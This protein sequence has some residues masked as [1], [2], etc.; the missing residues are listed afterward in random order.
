VL[1]TNH[2]FHNNLDAVG[3]GAQVIAAGC[4]IPDF[5]PDVAFGR[6]KD[7]LESEKRHVE[8]F[9]LLDSMRTHFDI[10]V[11]FDGEIPERV[12]ASDNERP[13]LKFGQW[14]LMPVKDGSTVEG[15]LYEAT[16]LENEKRIYGVFESREGRHFM[17]STP[18]TDNELAAWKRHP[19]TFFGEV[20]HVGGQS[21]NWLDLA[22]FLYQSYQRTPREKLL[23][24]MKGAP[25]LEE[26]SKLPQEELAIVYCERAALWADRQKQPSSEPSA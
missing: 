1:V 19:E 18:M 9:A 16:V 21:D 3:A 7:V 4:R 17:A 8:I 25:D 2:A 11:T 6:L 10:P 26:L 12:F 13:P 15:R 24:W 20:R 5:G 23:E 22:K 14:Y